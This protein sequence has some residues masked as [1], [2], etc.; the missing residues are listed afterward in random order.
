MKAQEPIYTIQYIRLY[1]NPMAKGHVNDKADLHTGKKRLSC[2]LIAVIST[3]AAY[4]QVCTRSD[5]R[6]TYRAESSL[7]LWPATE[8]LIYPRVF[9]CKISP[10]Y[11]RNVTVVL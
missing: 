6:N 7:T 3:R 10:S 4:I 5:G 8:G 9:F 2:R 11:Q 1:N